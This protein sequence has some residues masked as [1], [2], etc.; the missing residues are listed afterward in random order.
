MVWKD[1]FNYFVASNILSERTDWENLSKDVTYRPDPEGEF[2]GRKWEEL[3]EIERKSPESV[4]N[5][6]A[7]CE[8]DWGCFQWM[9]HGQE[10]GISHSIK[11]GGSR[12]PEGNER[13]V[14]GWMG[15]RIDDFRNRMG[16]CE[17]GFDW[18]THGP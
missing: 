10:C 7:L 17:G 1:V 2:N 5:C 9:H 18:K 12:R 11:L 15:K 13:W 3:E 4:E 16:E 8:Y 14:S 6:K